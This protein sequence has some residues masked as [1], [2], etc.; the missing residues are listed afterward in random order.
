MKKC[1]HC[2]REIQDESVVCNYCGELVHDAETG[3]LSPPVY[4]PVSVTKLVVMSIFTWGF[5]QL[6]WFYKNWQFHMYKHKLKIEPF[7]RGVFAVFFCYSLFKHIKKYAK[8]NGV[9][10][11]IIPELLAFFFIIMSI[12]IAVPGFTWNLILLSFIPLLPVQNLINNIN[13]T[14]SPNSEINRKYS[15]WNILIIVVG[16]FLWINAFVPILLVE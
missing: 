9:Q 5:Y 11:D 2:A 3:V 4:F 6:Y 14:L 10:T 1:P 16:I 13:K 15:I 7:W 12:S 8:T